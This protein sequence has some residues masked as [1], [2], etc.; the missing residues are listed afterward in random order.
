MDKTSLRRGGLGVWFDTTGEDNVKGAETDFIITTPLIK[1]AAPPSSAPL[2]P[3]VTKLL[4][5]TTTDTLRD[6][7]QEKGGFPIR[8]GLIRRH[9]KVRMLSTH[10]DAHIYLFPHWVLDFIKRN[11][12]FDSISEDVVGWWAKAAWQDGLALKLRMDNAVGLSVHR[13]LNSESNGNVTA[14]LEDIELNNLTS[15]Q[16]STLSKDHETSFIPLPILSYVHPHYSPHTI[17]RV[18]TPA[19]LLSTSLYLASLSSSIDARLDTPSTPLS[20]PHKISADPSLIAPHTTIHAPSTLIA[21]NTSVAKHCTIKSS[22]IGANCVIGEGARITGS[23]LMDGV[24][25]G[26]KVQMQGCILGRRCVIG[27]GA[28]L[29][30]CE[31]QDGFKIEDGTVGSKGEKFCVFE[32]LDGGLVEL[33]DDADGPGDDDED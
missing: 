18:D 31:V 9:G 27:K 3:D 10:R 24:Q 1:S 5:A 13:P 33:E 12:K 28:K 26:A 4:Y 29:E 14:S 2:R 21:P 6:I 20:H 30:G 7:T 8:N 23:L 16:P 22:C 17:R 15:T 32:G 25:V 19:L 11:E